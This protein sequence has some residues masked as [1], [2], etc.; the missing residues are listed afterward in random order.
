V[1]PAAPDPDPEPAPASAP[2]P[3][4]GVD[5][6]GDDVGVV[7]AVRDAGDHLAGALGGI[8]DQAPPPADVL[9]VDGGSVDDSASVARSF[10]GVRVESQRGHG[11]AGARNQ[12][13]AGVQGS[14][15]AFCDADDRWTPGSLARRVGHLRRHP[16]VGAVIGQVETRA[17]QGEAVPAAQAERLGGVTPGYTPSALVVRRTVLASLGAFD[18]TL[19]IGADSDWFVRLVQSDHHLAVLDDVVLVKGVRSTSLSTDIEAYRRELLV[20]ARAFVQRRR[21]GR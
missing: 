5:G 6:A 3:A 12:G 4:P 10:A 1:I 15:V 13:I 21:A 14:L 17:L 7:V 2:E 18:E 9:V 20:V 8:L 19:R 16:E 11:L